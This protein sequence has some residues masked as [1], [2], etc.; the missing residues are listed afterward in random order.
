M[1]EVAPLSNLTSGLCKKIEAKLLG[2]CAEVALIHGL[3]TEGLGM[4]AK[5][6]RRNFE[7]GMRVSIRCLTA[8]SWIRI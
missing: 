6:L 2:T 1:S 4:Q 8:Q 3:E 5:D 7:Y